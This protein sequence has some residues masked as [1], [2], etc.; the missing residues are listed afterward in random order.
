MPVLTSKDGDW[1]L[2]GKGEYNIAYLSTFITTIQGHVGRWVAKFPIGKATIGGDHLNDSRRFARKW[3]TINPDLPLVPYKGHTVQII[4]DLTTASMIDGVI[5]LHSNRSSEIYATYLNAGAVETKLID[6]I[7][8]AKMKAQYL[9]H[10]NEHAGLPKHLEYRIIELMQLHKPG[11]LI[12]YLGN[13]QA[14]DAQIARKVLDIYRSS[15]NIIA[16]ATIQ[17]NFLSYQDKIICVDL[18]QAFQRGSFASEKFMSAV[19]FAQF[20]QLWDDE[21]DEFPLTIDTI[22]TLFCLEQ[23]L[24][25]E[26]INDGYLTPEL[27]HKLNIC[28]KKQIPLNELNIRA[29]IE[30]LEYYP[31]HQAH[32]ERIKNQILDNISQSTNPDRSK[33]IQ[34]AFLNNRTFEEMFFDEFRTDN[35]SHTKEL[36][37]L[38]LVTKYPFGFFQTAD[39]NRESKKYKA[40]FTL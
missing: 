3:L 33:V 18:D 20:E 28:R 17:G 9:K 31:E 2:L 37:A 38:G 36:L 22:R 5:Y 1:F 14:S 29:L 25:P 13:T 32:E 24:N 30:I 39:E 40:D 8:S 35:T 26:Q 6:A 4:D 12:P 23:H 11:C 16:D 10:I 19:M 34:D 7:I 27:V 21:H 15:R